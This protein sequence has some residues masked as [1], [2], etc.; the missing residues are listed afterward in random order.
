MTA[1]PGPDS[2]GA[3]SDRVPPAPAGTGDVRSAPA[4]TGDVVLSIDAMGGDRGV[5]DVIRGMGKSLEKNTRLRY[6]VL[7]PH[8]AVQDAQRFFNRSAGH[9]SRHIAKRQVRRHQ[10]YP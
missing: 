3:S 10:S 2:G 4:G 8:L 1:D 7:L 5:D 9:G 6:T